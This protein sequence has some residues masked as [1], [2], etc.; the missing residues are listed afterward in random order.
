MWLFKLKIAAMK[1]EH[2]FLAIKIADLKQECGFFA[3][4]CCF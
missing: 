2:G 3:S 4:K 1:Q